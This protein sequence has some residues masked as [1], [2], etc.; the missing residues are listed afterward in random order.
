[1]EVKE[2]YLGNI[3]AIQEMRTPHTP[4]AVKIAG[5]SDLPNPLK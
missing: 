3:K 2:L 4:I 5:I 1:M